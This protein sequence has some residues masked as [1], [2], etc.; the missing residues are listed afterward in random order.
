M[1]A[2]WAAKFERLAE[3]L[4]SEGSNPRRIR[5]VGHAMFL[6]DL[7]AELVVIAGDLGLGPE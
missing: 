3:H 1:A 4:K 2:S 5:E 6:A 7:A